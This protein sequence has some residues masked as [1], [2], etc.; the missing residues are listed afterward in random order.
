MPLAFTDRG[1]KRITKWVLVLI[2]FIGVGTVY[3]WINYLVSDILS[4]LFFVVVPVLYFVVA[5]S[6][7]AWTRM[8]DY[9]VRQAWPHYENIASAHR[10]ELDQ[11]RR[12]RK[13]RAF[14][15]KPHLSYSE[16]LRVRARILNQ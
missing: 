11:L 12:R 16:Y 4:I 10:D 13:L 15:H 8:E 2:A 9:A 5:V 7:N 6:M 14:L 1:F 3:R